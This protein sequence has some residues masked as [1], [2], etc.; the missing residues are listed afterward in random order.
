MARYHGPVCRLCR[1]QGIKLFLK[2]ERCYTPKCA[3]ERRRP[4]PG[5]KTTS[6]RRRR[7][8]EW[9]VHLREKQKARQIYGV[10]EAQF[11]QHYALASREKGATGENLL[12]IL[13]SRLDNVIYRLGWADSRKES[14]QIVSHGHIALNGHRANIPSIRTKVGDTITWM[15]SS[16]KSVLFEVVQHQAHRRTAPPWLQMDPDKMEARVLRLPEKAETDTRIDDRLI[17]EF[18]SR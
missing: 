9:G 14:R 5:E 17:V 8:S 10:L 4:T 18:Y 16:R 1:R 3:I 2:G 13:E 6:R 15:P 7:L 12:R 11:R